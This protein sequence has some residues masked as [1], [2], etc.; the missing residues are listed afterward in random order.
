MIENR[1]PE[2][3]DQSIISSTIATWN[4]APHVR[5]GSHGLSIF[6]INTPVQRGIVNQQGDIPADGGD[7]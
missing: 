4:E 2:E 6:R 3:C 7:R 5:R 1:N